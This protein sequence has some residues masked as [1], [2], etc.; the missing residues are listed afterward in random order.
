MVLNASIS[1]SGTP[2]VSTP[3]AT[4]VLQ[5]RA[6]EIPF[7]VFRYFSPLKN[8]VGILGWKQPPARGP[9]DGFFIVHDI[10]DNYSGQVTLLEAASCHHQDWRTKQQLTY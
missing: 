6:V 7:S 10:N 8:G 5:S 9:G 2:L 4:L 3:S 1:W